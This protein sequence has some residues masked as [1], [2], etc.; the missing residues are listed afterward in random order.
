[1]QMKSFNCTPGGSKLMK[2]K[3]LSVRYIKDQ[4]GLIIK[5]RK[6]LISCL[7]NLEFFVPL[8]FNAY[9]VSFIEIKFGVMILKL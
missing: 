2:L 6:I 3:V 8:N 4:L 9:K 7:K 1:M 5:N